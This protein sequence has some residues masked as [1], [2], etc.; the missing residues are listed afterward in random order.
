MD[1]LAWLQDLGLE[2][3]AADFA[4]NDI[5]EETLAT[6]DGDD[7][8]ELGVASLGHRKKLLAA[9]AMLRG[10]LAPRLAD[11]VAPAP[12]QAK[13]GAGTPSGERR[14]V[15]VLF[16]DVTGY[17]KLSNQVDAEE[18]SEILAR[19]FRA[20]DAIVEDFGGTIDKH[21]GD[22][23]M[24]LFG[25][26]VAHDDDPAR[27]V[28]AASE[29]HRAMESIATELRRDLSLHIGIASGS[30]VA[31]GVGA[32]E[33]N[34]YT[35]TGHSVNLAARLNAQAKGGETIVSDAVKRA[36]ETLAEFKSLGALT[37]KGFE[38]PVPAWRVE[39]LNAERTL[40]GQGAF[41]GRRAELRQLAGAKEA[42]T[43]ERAGQC[44]VIR[45]EAGMGKSRLTA[46][47]ASRAAASGFSVH[48]GLVLDFG[49]GRGQDAMRAIVISILG[50]PLGCDGAA[51]S[52]AA[53]T[54]LKSG[55]IE[56][57]ERPFLYD[58]M[59][60]EQP[61]DERGRFEAMDNE[62]RNARKFAFIAALIER[63][64]AKAPILIVIEDIHWAEPLLMRCLAVIANRLV[65]CPALLLMTT[66]I[67]G[68]PIDQAWRSATR[69][70]PLLTVDLSPLREE[71]AVELAAGLFDLGRQFI[72][73]C[74]DKAEGNPLFL[75]QLLRN[76]EERGGDEIPASI[77]SLV[78][79]RMDRLPPAD[80]QALQAASVI[81][82]RFG[83]EEVRA[84][85]G[86]P[87]YDCASLVQHTLIRPEA[88]DY[89][90]VHA[91]IQQ[92]VYSSLLN[93]TRQRLHLRAAAYFADREPGL[94]AQHLDRAGDP[95]AAGAYLEAAKAQSALYHFESA[96]QLVDRG[97]ELSEDAGERAVLM[98]FKGT[99]LRELGDPAG[100]VAS[101]QEALK[102]A[103]TESHK[104]AAW[105]GLAEAARF[106]GKTSEGLGYLDLAQPA[107]EAAGQDLALAEIHHLRGNLVFP[108]GE[109]E[110][111]REE[112]Q[113]A[114]AY[115]E[116]VGSVEY[117]AR[118]LGGLGDAF[119]CSGRL[120]TSHHYLEQCLKLAEEN[121]L[122]SIEVSY[123]IMRCDTFMFRT[124]LENAWKDARRA[125][126][127]AAEVGNRRAEF[128][129]LWVGVSIVMF[130]PEK[131]EP[132][133]LRAETARMTAIVRQLGLKFTEPLLSIARAFENSLGGLPNDDEDLRKGYE[134][135]CQVGVTF[136][137]PWV[138]AVLCWLTKDAETRRWAMAEAEKVLNSN[139]CLSHNY[140]IFYQLALEV[141]IRDGIWN[142]VAHYCQAIDD[143]T[144]QER[145]P[146]MDFLMSRGRALKAV[147]EN[148]ADATTIRQIQRLR[149]E[150]AAMGFTLALPAFDAVLAESGIG[151]NP[152]A[153]KQA[154]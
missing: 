82:Q 108:L 38:D 142:D 23:V 116:K 28:R 72:R 87:G 124:E 74:I 5:D 14:Q 68:D 80:K 76:S 56:P 83:L 100:S 50:L 9:I 139:R 110:R 29:I 15:T 49:V 141:S 51:R 24:A 109:F 58:L 13:R 86:D 133:R 90:F 138:L 7:L 18:L 99:K 81:G 32:S 75:E 118:A 137:G 128:F 1:I 107:A 127:I 8:K 65:H 3:Y 151:P 6:L 2:R 54:A 36:T 10:G 91:L 144:R 53:E 48:K 150:A 25:A 16:A 30:V 129:G 70:C 131:I 115:A 98:C 69:E 134:L 77:Q 4:A 112:H 136:A 12:A 59:D 47:F 33:R 21:I 20:V 146:L 113:S 71:E 119:Y 153:S 145:L 57:D 26:P 97:L 64:S 85:C 106:A 125:A 27:A 84:L 147:A 44:I 63:K 88:R 143:Y 111:C 45:G 126:T 132:E 60:L 114:L 41:V 92:G 35:V 135:A 11:S 140:L 122:G 121:G 46:E 31:G 148:T 154:S 79:A 42:C 152:G 149:D 123:L 43:E 19:I 67:D 89:L 130:S 117:R 61:L 120:Q 66:R 55:L 95:A 73:E 103:P 34:E 37:V 101:Y 104:V 40:D 39:R 22:E 93:S 102:A 94:R 62:T 105:V 17:T 52:T 78:L 96:L